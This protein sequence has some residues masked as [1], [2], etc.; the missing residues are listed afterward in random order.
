[1]DNLSGDDSFSG[2]VSYVIGADGPK[3]TLKAAMAAAP[4]GAVIIL[5]KGTG[6]YDEGSRGVLGKELTIKTIGESQLNDH[7]TK[8]L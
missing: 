7:G 1:M 8:S 6:I 2:K 4:S 3:R 5:Q